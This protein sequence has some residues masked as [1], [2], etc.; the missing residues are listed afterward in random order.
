MHGFYPLLKNHPEI[1]PNRFYAD[2][3]PNY[4]QRD[5]RGLAQIRDIDLFDRFVRRC[6]GRIGHPLNISSLAN[7]A[8]VTRVTAENWFLLLEISFLLYRL[9]PYH[10]NHGKRLTKSPKLYFYDV[11]LAAYLL[12][13][14]EKSQV[15]HHPLRGSLFENLAITDLHKQRLHQAK[16]PASPSNATA[17]PTK[18]TVSAKEA[19]R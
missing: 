15:A 16:P 1:G 8:G 2:Y 11:G 19:S 17:T 13:I 10:R 6:A 5:V 14:Q 12:G 3:Y 9:Q 7:D 4:I 18:S